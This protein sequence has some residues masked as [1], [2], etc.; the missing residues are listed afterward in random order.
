MK[1]STLALLISL[2]ISS[3]A[4]SADWTPVLKEMQDSCKTD[5]IESIASKQ[6]RMPNNLKGDIISHK[7]DGYDGM[8]FSSTLTLKNATAFGYPISKI[9]YD[10]D[11]G[12]GGGVKVHFKSV[13]F[14]K[15]L[16]KFSYKV[17]KKTHKATLK[18]WKISGEYKTIFFQVDTKK[19]TLY[20]GFY[21]E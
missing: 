11:E 21:S 16:P 13:N 5:I 1:K 4:F 20:C 19:K 10:A 12:D 2:V 7:G 14:N 8:F 17:G 6:T 3:P 9:E 15:V 18:G